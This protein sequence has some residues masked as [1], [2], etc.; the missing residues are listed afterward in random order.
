MRAISQAI[1]SLLKIIFFGALFAVTIIAIGLKKENVTL[2]KDNARHD[3]IN[4]LNKAEFKKL[5]NS[6]Q[7]HWITKYND[8]INPKI[9]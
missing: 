7:Y 1:L 9:N 8:S 2:Q 3:S 6:Y 4:Q 5:T